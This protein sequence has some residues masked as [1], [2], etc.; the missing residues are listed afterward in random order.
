MTVRRQIIIIKDIAEI[1]N[2]TSWNHPLEEGE[3]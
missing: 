1:T 3:L 2:D